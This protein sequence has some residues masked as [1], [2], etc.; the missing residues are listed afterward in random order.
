MKSQLPSPILMYIESRKREGI[1]FC[2]NKA[3]L[4]LFRCQERRSPAISA[5]QEAAGP[6]NVLLKKTVNRETLSGIVHY[7]SLTR[8]DGC[9]DL[10]PAG[11]LGLDRPL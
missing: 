11:F 7:S 9:F 10:V 5:T 6:H 2:H 8:W 4:M 3:R 1:L